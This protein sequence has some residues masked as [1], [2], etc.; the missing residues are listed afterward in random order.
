MGKKEM[1]KA[2][3]YLALLIVLVTFANGRVMEKRSPSIGDD[4]DSAI[5]KVGDFAEGVV[6]KV[7][8]DSI[9]GHIDSA[10]DRVGDFAEGV[11]DKIKNIGSNSILSNPFLFSSIV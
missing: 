1:S 11:V 6:D 4:V 10:I 5:D 9:G 2:I 8:S 7:K 3:I